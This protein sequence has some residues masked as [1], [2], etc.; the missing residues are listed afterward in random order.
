M[1]IQK[2][3]ELS[4]RAKTIGGGQDY[5]LA[6]AVFCVVIDHLY[7][8]G[9]GKMDGLALF[10]ET[11]DEDGWYAEEAYYDLFALH[12]TDEEKDLVFTIPVPLINTVAA[13]SMTKNS[14][15]TA[16]D[17][18]RRSYE[19]GAEGELEVLWQQLFAEASKERVIVAVKMYLTAKARE[20]A[21][22]EKLLAGY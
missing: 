2:L 6:N 20:A 10:L 17:E 5:A 22:F 4:E 12:F 7:H 18:H 11:Q 15:I 14:T 1:N 3:Y 16:R 21:K 8:V 9:G 13:V 19:S